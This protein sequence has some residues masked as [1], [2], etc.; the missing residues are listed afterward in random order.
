MKKIINELTNARIKNFDME[1]SPHVLTWE[2]WYRGHLPSFHNYYIWNGRKNINMQ[3]KSLQMAKKVCEDWADLLL[4]E[5]CD[6]VLPNDVD[7][8]NFDKI[9]DETKFWMIANESVEQSFALGYGAILMSVKNLT[10]GSMGSNKKDGK[11]D[12]QF[13]NR[14]NITVLSTYNGN[15]TEA[16]FTT[17]NSD[18]TY[19]VL[20]LLNDKGTY[21]IYT[22]RQEKEDKTL[23]NI[24]HTDSKV[25]WFQ[26]IRPFIS[27][28]FIFGDKVLEP[29]ISIFGNSTDTLRA[30]DTKYD[31]YDN[32]FIAGR[33]R[34][35]VS[36]ETVIVENTKGGEQKKAFN[37]FSSTYHIL[38]ETADNSQFMKDESG[39]LRAS[40]HILAINSELNLLSA[41]VGLGEA[42]Y[43]FDGEG[44]ATATQVISENSKLFRTLKKHQILVEYALINLTI[45]M[46]EAS[47][48]YTDT[49]INIPIDKYHEIKVQFDDSIIEDKGTEQ[50]RDKED[51]AAG[52]MSPI[53]YR[54]R[55][56]GESYEEAVDQYRKYFKYD[57]INKY[58]PALQ[59]G[60]MTVKQ[61]VL[62]VEGKEDADMEA[63]IT[64]NLDRGG[65]YVDDILKGYDVEG[66]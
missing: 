25:A 66:E 42:F 39:P 9:M 52:L 6:I 63:Y 18:N 2:H 11:I 20:H 37:P 59:S 4:N 22:Y 61:F 40:E 7:R 30:I 41:K 15:I 28:N 17:E 10:V 53:E 62:E 5:K 16:M 36:D 56:Y 49:P 31:S 45:A 19:Y 33:K 12:F 60:A 64:E 14:K 55:W 43:R 3:L 38:P 26:V 48:K 47:V 21:D 29:Y 34:L 58:L 13:V 23:V 1:D 44:F 54:E 8:T 57:I 65:S 46:A 24:F 35:F 50:M 51:V 27:S 32:E